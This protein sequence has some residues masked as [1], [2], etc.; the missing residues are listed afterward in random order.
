VK[1]KEVP[2]IAIGGDS[3]GT[4]T[5]VYANSPPRLILRRTFIAERDQPS[6]P[7]I[8][9]LAKTAIG[10]FEPIAGEVIDQQ[11][12]AVYE[13]PR[14]LFHGGFRANGTKS[15]WVLSWQAPKQG[16]PRIG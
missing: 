9:S 13:W 5:A 10:K 15:Y 3:E 16:S 4:L 7:R 2:T 6:E 1:R 12:E 14:S 11:L 8:D